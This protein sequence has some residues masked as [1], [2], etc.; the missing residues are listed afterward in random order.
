[1]YKTISSEFD[2]YFKGATDLQIFTSSF[3]DEKIGEV[4]SCNFTFGLDKSRKNVLILFL[5]VICL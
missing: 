1:M 3:I 2:A 4:R 5:Y